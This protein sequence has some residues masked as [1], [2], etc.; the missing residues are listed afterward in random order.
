MDKNSLIKWAL[1]AG[2]AYLV[3]RYLVASGY[4]GGTAAPEVL[5]LTPGAQ[6][7]ATAQAATPLVVLSEAQITQA[8]SDAISYNG[9]DPAAAY[10]GYQWAWFFARSSIYRDVNFGP[11]EMGLSD[12][13]T[14]PIS[15]AVAKLHE[16]F[17]TGVSGLGRLRLLPSPAFASAWSM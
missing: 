13:E 9:D 10:N 16:I 7:P 11:R 2:A 1:I 4:L 12:T 17:S 8:L 5:P 15:T 3:Y 14:V 6:P